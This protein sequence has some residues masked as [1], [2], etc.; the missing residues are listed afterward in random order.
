VI[1]KK[2]LLDV[3]TYFSIHWKNKKRFPEC[4]L[5]SFIP[6]N[7][8]IDMGTVIKKNCIISNEIKSIGKHVYIGDGAKILNCSHIDNYSCISHDVKIG[9][10]N[11][12]LDSLS[13]NPKLNHMKKSQPTIIGADVLISANA[14]IMSG[15]KLGHGCVIGANS[16]VNQ[17]VPP[18][19]IFAGSPA[20]F[21][22]YRFDNKEIQKK[23]K[24]KWWLMELEEI[25]IHF[26]E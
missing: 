21:I 3:R 23:L 26:K 22:R 8:N 11:H 15:I 17:D 12:Q 20:K 2:I 24:T 7:I 16:F 10:D 25:K 19:A 1:I 6:K 5:E 14:V 9:L 13:I 4:A 18:Y